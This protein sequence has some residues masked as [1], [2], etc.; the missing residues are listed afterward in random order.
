[1]FDVSRSLTSLPFLLS[2]L[3]L[4]VRIMWT[5]YNT[6]TDVPVESVRELDS[7]RRCR[8]TTPPVKKRVTTIPTC[9]TNPKKC[10]NQHKNYKQAASVDEWLHLLETEKDVKSD[11]AIFYIHEGRLRK[12]QS[13]SRVH[14]QSVPDCIY[15]NYDRETKRRVTPE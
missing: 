4:Q 7:C 5:S 12:V 11:C 9:G 2:H 15:G 8:H 3:H 14:P 6:L 1:M 10:Q 13:W